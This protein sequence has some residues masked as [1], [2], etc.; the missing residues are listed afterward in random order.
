MDKK[1]VRASLP[2]YQQKSQVLVVHVCNPSHRGGTGRRI[3][4]QAQQPGKNMRSYLKNN[5]KQKGLE[6]WLKW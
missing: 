2:P 5:L 6:T 1:L 3:T 4:V